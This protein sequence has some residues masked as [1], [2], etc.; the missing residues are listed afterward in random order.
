MLFHVAL[1]PDEHEDPASRLFFKPARRHLET[2]LW[3]SGKSQKATADASRTVQSCC[4]AGLCS[5]PLRAAI[6]VANL[7]LLSSEPRSC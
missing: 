3:M 5:I 7:L 2:V 6:V 1:R 4:V